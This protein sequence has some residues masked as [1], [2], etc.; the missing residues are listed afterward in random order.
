MVGML[1]GKVGR[2]VV[3]DGRADAERDADADAPREPNGLGRDVALELELEVAERDMREKDG[4]GGCLPFSPTLKHACSL[5]ECS[6]HGSGFDTPPPSGSGCPHS[7]QTAESSCMY[8]SRVWANRAASAA[9]LHSK[10][11]IQSS[12]A[13]ERHML[14]HAVEPPGD[15]THGSRRSIKGWQVA[16]HWSATWR[17][18]VLLIWRGERGLL[19]GSRAVC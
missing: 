7:T 6:T 17:G 16:A 11:T 14:R 4:S 15:W 1:D 2:E 3:A 13:R 10:H 5:H 12:I 18:P 9:R 19:M 8:S